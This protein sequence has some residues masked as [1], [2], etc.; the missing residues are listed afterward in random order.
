MAGGYCFHG[1]SLRTALQ[2]CDKCDAE[3]ANED[4]VQRVIQL[5]RLARRRVLSLGGYDRDMA[6]A[7]GLVS[8]YIL[9]LANREGLYPTFVKGQGHC[10]VR[11]FNHVIDASAQQLHADCRPVHVTKMY[12]GEVAL[13]NKVRFSDGGYSQKGDTAHNQYAARQ[14][15][16]SWHSEVHHRALL[17]L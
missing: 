8:W 13:S 2:G 15:I 11:Y 14:L 10:W 9:C 5:A 16:S 3:K 6:G 12:R 17:D 7:C 1:V 4:K